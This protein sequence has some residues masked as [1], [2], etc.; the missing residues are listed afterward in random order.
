M[1]PALASRRAGVGPVS[2]RLT[3]TVFATVLL[4]LATVVPASAQVTTGK[5][6]G[7]VTDGDTGAPISGAQIRVINS[8]LGNL[9]NEQGF[10][11]INEVAAGL[12]RIEASSLG[13]RAPIVDGERI[14]AGQTTTINFELGQTAVE[15]EAI[16]VEGERNPLVP[17]DQVSS[18]SIVRGETVDLL[19][20]DIV[21]KVIVLQPGAYEVNCDDSNELDGDFDGRCI[22]IRGG[23]PNEDALYID[24]V[25][26]RSFGTGSAHNVAVPTNSLEQLDVT[27]GGFSAEFGEAQS[28]V[29][30]YVTRT[31]GARLSGSLEVATDRLGPE[32]WTTNFNR[33]EGNL[34]GPVFGPLSF[35]LAGSATGRSF[36]DNQGGPGYWVQSG[37]DTC[38]DAPQFGSLC[39]AGEPAVF[40]LPRASAANGAIDS[41]DL[42]APAFVLSDGRIRPYG[43]SDNYL[44]TGNLNWQLP[45]GSRVTFGY[46]RNR[47]QN[48]QRTNSIWS[49][50]RTDNMDGRLDVRNVF[51][52]GSF[53]TLAQSATHQVALD[54][55]I[56]YQTDQLEEGIVDPEW[57]LGHQSPSFGFTASDVRFHVDPHTVRQGLNLFEPGPLELRAGRSGT[58]FQDSTAV[59]PGR[60]D[61]LRAKQTVTG[62]GENLRANP[63]GWYNSFPIS[64]Q[65]NAGL[66]IRKEDRLQ[67]RA[68][69]DW[70]IGRFNRLKLGGEFIDVDLSRA[71]KL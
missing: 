26:V 16:T 46:T 43:W 49:M 32:T 7:R 28:G 71:D 39:A 10:Y 4:L 25:L 9:T 65:G 42:A 24:G 14:L 52:L 62:I 40:R 45:R 53:L 18:K 55:R 11:F 47:F 6:Q 13:Y 8:T 35:F 60:Q 17:R 21:A 64:G 68:A 56:S 30:S 63:Y 15:L 59:Y 38:P 57:Y 54:A 37:I 5:I 27:V 48:Y 50:Y 31:G 67:A 69:L 33:L 66:Q 19:P 41:V 1:R 12:Q 2:V 3:I 51:T 44:F 70:Q 20:V 23:R 34:G 22:S 58:V 29:V 36:F 61:Q